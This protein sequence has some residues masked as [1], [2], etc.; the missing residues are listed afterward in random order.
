MEKL[1]KE[2]GAILIY[3]LISMLI[4]IILLMGVYNLMTNKHITQLEVAQQIKSTYEEDVNNIDAIYNDLTGITDNELLQKIDNLIDAKLA[5]Y[6]TSAQVS[7]KIS[8]NSVGFPDYANRT[9]LTLGKE[10]TADEN[11][12]VIIDF[13]GKR[14]SAASLDVTIDNVVYEWS[15]GV[16]NVD[17]NHPLAN[18]IPIKQGSMYKIECPGAC[19]AYKVSMI[20]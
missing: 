20:Y 9:A 19:N 10:Y 3:V 16:I 12:Y 6:D 11:M 8:T 17:Y 15:Q 14:E 5:N 2:K 7:N 1:K 13:T 4:L 18:I